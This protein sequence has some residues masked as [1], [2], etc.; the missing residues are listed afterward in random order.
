MNW[1]YSEGSQQR[2]PV[3]ESEWNTLIREGKIR[4]DTLVWNERM[5]NWEP[6]SRVVASASS[7][8]A[9]AGDDDA[10]GTGAEVD[11]VRCSE[12]GNFFPPDETVQIG[13]RQVCASCK[14]LAVQKMREGVGYGEGQTVDPE[15]LGSEIESRG[16]DVRIGEA[17]GRSWGVIKR[18]FWPAIGV[19]LL[20]YLVMVAAQQLP[21]IGIVAAF[22]VQ[23]QM[24]A[25]LYWYFLK[26]IRGDEAVLNDAFE[27]FRRGFGQQ[28]IYALIMFL[29]TLGCIIPL[30][31]LVTALAPGAAA[32]GQGGE[33]WAQFGW[34]PFV[35][36]GIVG[37]VILYFF[38]CWLFVPLL[39][40]DKGL[41]AT[42][43]MRLSRR[44]VH[45]HFWKFFLL[46]L[47]L[48]LLAFA[49]LLALIIGVIFILPLFFAT[50]SLVY[51][52]IFSEPVA[53]RA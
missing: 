38:I 53:Q 35:L 51:E 41:T 52:D 45:M 17:I 15:A 8:P 24:M 32:A 12:C 20:C 49:G 16:Y 13:S 31:V 36:G 37:L 5:T 44:V 1:Y 19:T 11:S 39:I 40:L 25:G 43:A 48:G 30:V 10:A 4:P 50:L 3:T 22:L 29:I 46:L 28:A 18:N 23:P 47:S 2:G 9:R 14:P 42:V 7:A 34:V 33:P 27:G 21:L 6:Y 26:Q